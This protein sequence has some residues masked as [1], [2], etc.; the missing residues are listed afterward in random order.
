[1]VKAEPFRLP[2]RMGSFFESKLVHRYPGVLGKYYR[3]CFWRGHS[4]K[5][6]FPA[7]GCH[8]YRQR[9]PS[10]VIIVPE[11]F[12]AEPYGRFDPQTTSRE[13]SEVSKTELDTGSY[14]NSTLDFQIYPGGGMTYK[15]SFVPPLLEN[16]MPIWF[17]S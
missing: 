16:M 17:L 6:S 14:R 15:V 4:G 9:P 11:G 8:Q 13:A 2:Q 1:M 3:N 5:R 10:G 12:S 7:Y